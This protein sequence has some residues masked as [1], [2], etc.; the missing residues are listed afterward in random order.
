MVD[1][2]GTQTGEIS[3]DTRFLLMGELPSGAEAEGASTAF[4]KILKQADDL[5]ID[6]MSLD[7]FLE[8]AFG[9]GQM[10]EGIA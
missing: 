9:V 1:E 3:I 8:A 7:K 4:S 5:G 2:S 6:R 10:V